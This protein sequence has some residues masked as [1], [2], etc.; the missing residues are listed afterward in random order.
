[1]ETSVCGGSVDSGDPVTVRDT[2]VVRVTMDM[3]AEVSWLVK[4]APG[5]IVDTEK[6]AV[7]VVFWLGWVTVV[8]VEIVLSDGDSMEGLDGDGPAPEFA[9]Q[10]FM[11]VNSSSQ[12]SP[13]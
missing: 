3:C 2:M 9:K 10:P 11:G 8:L 13:Q 4:T 7:V 1:M 12:P 5:S 6:A